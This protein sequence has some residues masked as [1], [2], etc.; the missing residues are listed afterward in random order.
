MSSNI[1]VLLTS[2][3]NTSH[4]IKL[5]SRAVGFY[6]FCSEDAFTLLMILKYKNTQAL[7][8]IISQSDD[9]ITYHVTSGKLH[10]ILVRGWEWKRQIMS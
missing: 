8:S 6:T 1:V 2:Y 7:P 9:T 4:W 10:Y 5:S 3:Y